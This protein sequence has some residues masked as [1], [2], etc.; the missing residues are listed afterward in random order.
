M[1][2]RTILAGV[3]FTCLLLSACAS[4]AQAATEAD[5][6]S[7]PTAAYD[8][9]EAAPRADQRPSASGSN[10]PP[11]F[12]PDYRSRIAS[13][14]LAEYVG[15]SKGPPE[16]T[17]PKMRPIPNSGMHMSVCVG[18]PV[19]ILFG[20]V[21]ATRMRRWVI[22]AVPES[23]SPGRFAFKKRELGNL[24]RCEGEGEM[25]PF[26]E[27]AQVGDKLKACHATG[28]RRCTVSRGPTGRDIVV[29]PTPSR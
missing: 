16:I 22:F 20:L 15:K 6:A 10:T 3:C 27:L 5:H 23:G 7:D 14:L 21:D 29:T 2:R 19:A 28:E 9:A 26:T 4:G 13:A 12:P 11:I 8:V 25:K 18:F 17:A 24:D 1:R